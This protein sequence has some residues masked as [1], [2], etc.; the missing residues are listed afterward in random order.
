MKAQFSAC[1]KRSTKNQSEQ[2][3]QVAVGAKGIVCDESAALICE[4][5]C[6]SSSVFEVTH[7]VNE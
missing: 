6:G 3:Q 2:Q 4:P 7:S 1:G 5:P